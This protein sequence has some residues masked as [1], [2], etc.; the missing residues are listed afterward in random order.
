MKKKKVDIKPRE[1]YDL[2]KTEFEASLNKINPLL[3]EIEETD[4]KIDQM[5]YE[6]YGLTDE[7]IQIV[8]KGLKD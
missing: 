2:L 4:N 1:N 3:Q 5:V 7:E 8:E 6:L